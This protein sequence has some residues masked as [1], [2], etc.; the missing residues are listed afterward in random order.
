MSK[1]L[2]CHVFSFLLS[3][4]LYWVI[5]LFCLITKLYPTLANPWTIAC[6]T[7]LSMGF[8]RREYCSGLPF[9]SPRNLPEPGIQ[10]T[11]LM[12]P[13]LVGEFFTT[14]ATWEFY[15]CFFFWGTAK[16]CFKLAASF[17]ISTSS[18]DY[19]FSVF[20]PI[21]IIFSQCL[22]RGCLCLIRCNFNAQP[23]LQCCHSLYFL[24]VQSPM[25]R[26]DCLVPFQVFHEHAHRPGHMY[27][28]S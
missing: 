6:Q 22:L 28:V 3:I 7:L 5:W 26:D 20:F 27:V 9:P 16:R 15:I 23:G 14:S 21:L 8:P 12:S 18:V 1:F 17:Y 2:W 24:L 11:S 10:P 25:F 19:S 4:Y 13:V